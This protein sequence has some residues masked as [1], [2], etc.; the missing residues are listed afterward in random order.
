ML[1]VFAGATGRFRL[2]RLTAAS[3]VMTF[4]ELLRSTSLQAGPRHIYLLPNQ[5]ELARPIPVLVPK[6]LYG[7]HSAA[8]EIL[9]IVRGGLVWGHDGWRQAGR[10]RP[11]G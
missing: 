2:D 11:G 9:R 1:E 4:R 10:T 8:R 3:S 7:R 5:Q 6:Y